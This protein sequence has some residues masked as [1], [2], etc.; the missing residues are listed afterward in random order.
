MCGIT[1]I[2]LVIYS[3]W[4][5]Y[6]QIKDKHIKARNVWKEYFVDDLFNYIDGAGLILTLLIVVSTLSERDWI[7]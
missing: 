7:T 3:L 5:E 2:I 1:L 4:I 6:R